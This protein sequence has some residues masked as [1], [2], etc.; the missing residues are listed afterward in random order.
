MTTERLK[1]DYYY[2]PFCGWCYASARALDAMAEAYPQALTMWPTG[3]FANTGRQPI[4]SMAE[5]SWRNIQRI[6]EMTG[7][8][9]TTDYRDRVLHS[10]DGIFDSIYATRAVV[11]LGGLDPSLEPRLLHALQTARYGDAQDTAQAGVVAAIATDVAGLQG[12]EMV[13]A[14]FAD[15]LAL[16]EELAARTE[17]RMQSA[18][19]R[20]RNLPGSG[21]PRLLVAVGDHREVVDGADLYGGGATVLAAIEAVKERA[22]VAG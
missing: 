4:S 2:D 18:R 16:D 15:Y 3:L 13:V 19:E 10:P 5:H 22:S 17:A 1:L 12:V 21:I 14:P 8:R 7:Q 9:V 6:A 11:A 20:L